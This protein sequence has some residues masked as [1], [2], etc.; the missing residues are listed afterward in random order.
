MKQEGLVPTV[1]G[2]TEAVE[3]KF[4]DDDD[5]GDETPD[6]DEEGPSEEEADA[7]D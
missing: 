1:T 7:D 4:P 2:A 6:E 5:I 3:T